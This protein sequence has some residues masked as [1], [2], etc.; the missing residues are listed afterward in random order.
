MPYPEVL[1]QQPGD[2]LPRPTTDFEQHIQDAVDSQGL[3]CVAVEAALNQPNAAAQS[4]EQKIANPVAS[5]YEKNSQLVIAF[6]GVTGS[7]QDL[8]GLCPKDLSK[9]EPEVLDRFAA[10]MVIVDGRYT[11]DDSVLAL[12][13]DKKRDEYNK[14]VSTRMQ[15]PKPEQTRDEQQHNLDA[16]DDTAK[17]LPDK[18]HRDAALLP[19]GEKVEKLVAATPKTKQEI[20]AAT[21]LVQEAAKITQATHSEQ[22]SNTAQRLQANSVQEMLKSTKAVSELDNWRQQPTVKLEATAAM[23]GSALIETT[24]TNAIEDRARRQFDMAVEDLSTAAEFAAGASNEPDLAVG[25]VGHEQI[26]RADEIFMA[27]ESTGEADGDTAYEEE[28]TTL[29]PLDA[30]ESSPLVT[31]QEF[32][33]LWGDDDPDEVVQKVAARIIA[34]QHLRLTGKVDTFIAEITDMAP[35]ELPELEQKVLA[36]WQAAP[37]VLPGSAIAFAETDSMTAE[38]LQL[39]PDFMTA[40]LLTT[41]PLAMPAEAK[42]PMSMSEITFAQLDA[43][44]EIMEDSPTRQEGVVIVAAMH[45]LTQQVQETTALLQAEF[46]VAFTEDTIPEQ[47]SFML[48]ADQPL[49]LQDIVEQLAQIDPAALPEEII[50]IYHE[51]LQKIAALQKASQKFA[52]VF[53]VTYDPNTHELLLSPKQLQDPMHERLLNCAFWHRLDDTN[54]GEEPQSKSLYQAIAHLALHRTRNNYAL[55]A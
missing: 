1:L 46:A 9:M 21:Q 24:A 49:R 14:T 39:S 17:S 55:A 37:E 2:V 29:S 44:L 4:P 54:A 40:Q 30:T 34:E 11:V 3:G 15:P 18:K 26:S 32:A 41:E 51:L 47:L 13:S 12:V 20:S 27:L 36:V 28:I 23:A 35:E 5:Y 42:Q 25:V 38:K 48:H 31:T 19:D 6:M 43:Q 10:E 53:A 8:K 45:E 7:L 50:E 52:E 33:A 22:I 16:K